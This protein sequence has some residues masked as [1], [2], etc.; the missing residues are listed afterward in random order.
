MAIRLYTD[1]N[2]P[3]AISV[4]LRQRNVD[5]LTAL[6]NGT[7]ELDDPE[8][9]DRVTALGRILFTRDYHLLQEAAKRQKEGIEFSGV[10]YAHQ[11]RISIGDCIRELEV[12]AKAG[13]PGDL[14]NRVEFLPLQNL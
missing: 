5:I 9:L 2:V 3:R 1:H 4:G 13:E 7:S 6:E 11:L 10:I 8:L 14:R 12:I